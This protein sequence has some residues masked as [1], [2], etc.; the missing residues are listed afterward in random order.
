MAKTKG[1]RKAKHGKRHSRKKHGGEIFETMKDIINKKT[2]LEKE[3]EDRDNNLEALEVLQY[4]KIYSELKPMSERLLKVTNKVAYEEFVRYRNMIDHNKHNPIANYKDL[5]KPDLNEKI[6]SLENELRGKVGNKKDGYIE[7]ELNTLKTTCPTKVN[8]DVEKKNSE[9]IKTRYTTTFQNTTEDS[10]KSEGDFECNAN[11][12]GEIIVK[13]T[14]ATDDGELR[15]VNAVDGIVPLNIETQQKFQ[16]NYYKFEQKKNNTEKTVP[17]W[18]EEPGI[19]PQHK[20]K[21]DVKRSMEITRETAE[22]EFLKT[23][24][25]SPTYKLDDGSPN[26]KKIYDYFNSERLD[27]PIVL[28][29]E[30]EKF[31]K[32]KGLLLKN[33][34]LRKQSQD[35]NC[36]HDAFTLNQIR[37]CDLKDKDGN[38]LSRNRILLLIHP[39]KQNNPFCNE[40]A[41]E[42]FKTFLNK[43]DPNADNEGDETKRISKNIKCKFGGK[44]KRSKKTQRKRKRKH[45]VSSRH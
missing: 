29:E 10:I 19:V 4:L 31:M 38:P 9:N 33:A 22:R 27:K 25:D 40:E 16:K 43:D 45:R 17:E 15:T 12:P 42:K 34:T 13:D 6:N 23:W 35:G 37:T 32:E 26:W 7:N 39:D 30:Y 14:N 11:G 41:G 3:L 2:K 20:Y 18:K 36:K 1:I 21:E 5:S 28:T 8:V 44:K 24:T